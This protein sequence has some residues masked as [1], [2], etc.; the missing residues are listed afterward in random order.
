MCLLRGKIIVVN[1]I[2]MKSKFFIFV[3]GSGLLVEGKVVFFD[4]IGNLIVEGGRFVF[5]EPFFLGDFALGVHS[6]GRFIRC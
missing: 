2:S 1:V 4:G 3:E 6:G 5:R